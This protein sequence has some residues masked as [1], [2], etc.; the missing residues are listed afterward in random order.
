MEVAVMCEYTYVQRCFING[1]AFEMSHVVDLDPHLRLSLSS[2]FW[3]TLRSSLKK[4]TTGD[5]V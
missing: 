1:D 4:K 2:E 3:L 5:S